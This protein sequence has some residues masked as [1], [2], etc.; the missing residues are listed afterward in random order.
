MLCERCGQREA[1]IRYTEVINGVRSEHN[2][3][4]QCA[5]EMELGGPYAAIFDSE[6]PLGRLLSGLLGLQTEDESKMEDEARMEQ[7][8]CP[9]CKTTYEEFIKNSRFGCPDC[10]QMFDLLMSDN[11]KKL[12]GSDT[13]VGKR[14]KYGLEETDEKERA[15]VGRKSQEEELSLLESRLREAIAEEEYETAAKYRDQIK[16]LKERMNADA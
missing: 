8:S 10:Y 4:S 13:H 1:N 2:L 11:I 14:P 5:R 6:F 7:L 15:D 16:E 9:T 12:Q 3:C